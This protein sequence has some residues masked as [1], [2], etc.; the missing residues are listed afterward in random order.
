[1][2][3]VMET[4]ESVFNEHGLGHSENPPKPGVHTTPCP[5]PTPSWGKSS[6]G[7]SRD[8]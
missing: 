4:V 6:P 2:K 8:A 1:M 3:T 5:A 7:K